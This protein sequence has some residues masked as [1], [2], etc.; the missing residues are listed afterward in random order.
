MTNH[1]VRLIVLV[2]ALLLAACATTPFPRG[3]PSTFLPP[4]DSTELDHAVAGL[5]LAPDE[6]AYSL[7]R[8]GEDEFVARMVSI[9]QAGRS[10]DAQY[11]LWHDDLTGRAIGRE[12]L[13]AADRGVRV[14]I[15]LDD[16]T[17]R[18]HDEELAALDAHERIEIRVFNPFSTRGSTIG[19][20]LE[21]IFGGGRVNHRMHNKL[22]IADSQLAIVGG[23]NIGDEY[24]G[25][26]EE[27]NFGDL[28]VLMAGHVVADADAQFDLFWNSDSVVPISAFE[29][30][31]DPDA[32]LAKRRAAQEAHRQEALETPYAKHLIQLRDEGLTGLH[33]DSLLRGRQVKLVTDDP[34]KSKGEDNTP[35]IMLDT[36]TGLLQ[37]AQSE[38]VIIS[39]YFVP[40]RPG[41]DL[42]V[43]ME[44]RGVAS[45]LLTN[46]LAAN[47]VASVHGGYSKS[48][49]ELLRA[50]VDIHELKPLRVGKYSQHSSGTPSKSTASLHAKSVV[51]DGHLA[52]VGSFNMDPRSARI[53]TEC[54]VIIDD[55]AFA[56]QVHARYDAATDLEH[57][58]KLAL[59]G[60]KIVWL[61][62]VDG[63]PV[64]LHDEPPASGTKRF[65]AWM[66]S[67]LPLDS[68]L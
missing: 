66:F 62:Q 9:A 63:K 15:L 20:G 6:S 65:I 5:A 50:G 3:A 16:V 42:L 53:N 31:K 48:R 26:H 24:F 12:L 23:R 38:A 58:W 46:S 21:F 32:A 61:D 4:G 13:R 55:P 40:R 17:A 35:Q 37:S 27:V 43:S 22:W 41:T 2:A 33:L 14:R 39:P 10:L 19:N 67:W 59:E 57:S 44:K 11:Y 30:P 68:Q 45:H 54:G 64:T 51:T 52:F 28:G 7:F 25:A 36:I 60:D 29:K 49:L 1:G 56:A 8:S 34:S 47:D 18:G